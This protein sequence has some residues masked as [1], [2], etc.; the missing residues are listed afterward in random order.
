VE[1]Q[2]S[3]GTRLRRLRL[4][5]GHSLTD[6]AASIH[7]SKGYLRRVETGRQAPT[8]DLARRCDAA[9]GADGQLAALVPRPAPEHATW[10]SEPFS[11]PVALRFARDGAG[12]MSAL[13]R[14]DALTGAAA[15]AWGLTLN[16][17]GAPPPLHHDEP[18]QALRDLFAHLRRLG[19][20]SSASIILPMLTAQTRVVVQLAARAEPRLRPDWLAL[21]ARYAEY[22]GWL[23]Q[24]AGDEAGA[25]WWT[26][27]AAD[28]AYGAGDAEFAGYALVRQALIAMYRGDHEGTVALARAARA[29]A[30]TAHVQAQAARREAQ[31]HALAG[32]YSACMRCLDQA[33]E[34][35]AATG[36]ESEPCA[37]TL[38]PT[39]LPDAVAVITGWCLYDLGRPKQAADHLEG[40][41]ASLAP[42]ALRSHARYG[43]RR[44]LAQAASGEIDYACDL[45]RSLLTTVDGVASATVALDLR[46]LAHV[47]GRHHRRPAVREITADLTQSLR[48]SRT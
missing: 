10:P 14:R 47:L 5:A 22:T 11:G 4:A 48:L 19:Q 35:A 30:T 1:D 38:G 42:G 46:R 26:G 44:A 12:H 18:V 13:N 32:D 31:G 41:L 23:T 27:H 20:V 39:H 45:T 6:F 28:M 33:R 8:A 25:M 40:Q 21:A 29:E 3:F 9:L 15:S 37:T 2:A 36:S 17:W 43:I 34:L 7:Y 16:P 24:E